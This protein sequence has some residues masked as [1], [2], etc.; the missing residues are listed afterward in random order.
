MR[1]GC[2]AERAHHFIVIFLVADQ[3][4]RVAFP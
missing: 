4:D 1:V 2:F 3:D